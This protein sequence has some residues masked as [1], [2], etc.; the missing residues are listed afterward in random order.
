MTAVY[1]FSAARALSAVAVI[2]AL[3]ACETSSTT[4]RA[5]LEPGVFAATTD[6][7]DG[8]PKGTCWGRTFEPAVVERVSERIEVEPARFNPDGT[9]AAA[10]IYETKDRQVI[11][12]PRKSNWFET[13]CTGVL[14]R[15]FVSTLQR[16]LL[17]RGH[18]GG[19][20][21]GALD[22]DTQAAVQTFQ[23]A[24]GLDS[25]LLSLESARAL[26]LIAV[27]RPVEGAVEG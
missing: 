7:P 24:N 23:R 26:G 9:I 2:T 5:T 20:V 8:A 16:A 27:A 10:P 18:Y 22:A 14:T 11:V 15:E 25:P 1:L 4:S 3:C 19:A 17:A 21:T 12:T 6:G 13:P